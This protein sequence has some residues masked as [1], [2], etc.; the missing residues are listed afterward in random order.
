MKRRN[1]ARHLIRFIGII[2]FILLLYSIDFTQVVQ[3]ALT[4]DT[5]SVLLAAALV[6]PVMI[7]KGAR[8]H[9]ITS[10]LDLRLDVLEAVDGLCIAQ[11]MSFA[12]PGALG[13][14]VRVPYLKGRGNTTER[15]IMSVFLD[16]VIASFVPYLITTIALLAILEIDYLFVLAVIGSVAI[17]LFACYVTYRFL[18][19]FLSPWLIGVRI[20][21][22]KKKGIPGTH[23]V[24]ISESLRLAG[25]KSLF[26]A[27]M[28]AGGAWLL[29]AIQG[30]LLARALN[31]QLPWI[32]VAL[33]V[34]ITAMFVTVPISIQGIGVREGILLIV[35]GA[36]GIDY[37]T[38]ITFSI[39]LM[40]ISLVPSIWGLASW[41]RDPFIRI[42][43]ESIE[44]AILEPSVFVD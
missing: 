8:W 27:L 42:E 30:V 34:T 13:D 2:L 38:V 33:A 15:S 12:L 3:L 28:L 29:F 17:F 22:L 16:A 24:G 32:S 1:L 31:I 5:A 21:R 43:E 26:L 35:F 36:M 41:L 4:L 18:K 11:M 10:A 37:A 7:L 23:S 25:W 39:I 44:D 20:K 19:F 6:V 9:V 14:L 40:A